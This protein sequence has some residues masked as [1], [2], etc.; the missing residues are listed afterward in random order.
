MADIRCAEY[1]KKRQKTWRKRSQTILQYIE[2]PPKIHEFKAH[3]QPNSS[4]AHTKEKE[5]RKHVGVTEGERFC[6]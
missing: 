5:K 6:L 2:P 1:I 4:T 3:Q